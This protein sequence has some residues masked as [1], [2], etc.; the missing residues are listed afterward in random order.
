MKTPITYYGGKQKMLPHILPLIP[1]HRIYTE[2]FFGGGAVFFAKEK[3][4]SE[5][6][7]DTNHMVIDFYRVLREDFQALKEKIE[8]TLFSRATYK[9]AMSIYELPQLFNP[10]QR[11]WAFYIA[12]NMGFA[13]SVGSWGFDKYGKRSKSFLNRKLR[14]DASIARRLEQTT[15]E[16]TD[17]NHV[18]RTYDAPDAFHY[19]DP[20]YIA[21]H[22]GH[23]RGYTEE[24]FRRLLDTLAGV[25]G[26][27]LLSSFPSELLDTYIQKHGWYTQQFTKNNTAHKLQKGNRRPVK[28][29]V[30]TANYP[31]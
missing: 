9:V 5:V 1:P 11:A 14:F 18:I 27:F 28:T 25:Q 26:K 7:S 2:S 24:D 4:E 12:T 17:A 21:T 22:Q 31:I 6:I 23:Y 8:G 19:A 20:P 30:L 13:C 10:L 29:E 15:I 3:S 16:C